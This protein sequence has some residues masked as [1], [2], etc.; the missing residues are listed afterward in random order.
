MQPDPSGQNRTRVLMAGSSGSLQLLEQGVQGDQGV[1]LSSW[2]PGRWGE[3]G[4]HRRVASQALCHR[5]DPIPSPKERGAVVKGLFQLPSP[6]YL[7]CQR[8]APWWDQ[9]LL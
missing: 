6:H 9:P 8:Q 5:V 7:G 2:E 1:K 3:A 4:R